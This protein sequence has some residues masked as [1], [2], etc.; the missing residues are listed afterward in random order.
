MA[1]LLDPQTRD[2]GMLVLLSSLV[3][4]GVPSAILVSAHTQGMIM[5]RS[6]S[7]EESSLMLVGQ[8][9]SPW[10]SVVTDG[11]D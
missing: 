11:D 8:D 2:Y 9:L 6:H 3:Q 4:R 1:S 10:L 5:T 7:A